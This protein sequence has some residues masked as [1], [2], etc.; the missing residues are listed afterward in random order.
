MIFG[1]NILVYACNHRFLGK[2]CQDLG[3]LHAVPVIDSS[4]TAGSYTVISPSLERRVECHN[5]D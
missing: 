2:C 4:L 3:L 1:R 5:T